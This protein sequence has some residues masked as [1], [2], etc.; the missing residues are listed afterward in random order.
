MLTERTT[1]LSYMYFKFGRSNHFSGI[2]SNSLSMRIL[3]DKEVRKYNYMELEK[4][5]WMSFQIQ[6]TM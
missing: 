4:V 1:Q 3:Q 6:Q 2:Q 5:Q